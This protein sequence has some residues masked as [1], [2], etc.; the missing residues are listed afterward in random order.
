MP[1]PN[2]ISAA[3]SAGQPQALDRL[4]RAIVRHGG[5]ITHGAKD[6]GISYQ[7]LRKK[8]KR[9]PEVQAAIDRGVAEARAE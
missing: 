4:R 6:L 9:F 2:P 1:A 8:A 3:L 5:N 7:A